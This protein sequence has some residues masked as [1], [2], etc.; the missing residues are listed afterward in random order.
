M[1]HAPGLHSEG[2]VE[3]ALC[4]L[5]QAL[6]ILDDEDLALAAAKVDEARWAVYRARGNVACLAPS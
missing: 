2:P 3:Q 1:N 5:E 4:L 6:T